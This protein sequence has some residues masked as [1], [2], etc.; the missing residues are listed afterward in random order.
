VGGA[1]VIALQAKVID[2]LSD[3]PLT[4]DQLAADVG[5]PDTAE[6]IFLLLEH[7]VAKGRAELANAVSGS[8]RRV[9]KDGKR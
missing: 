1:S 7:L 9:A 8:F 6:T 2:A 5:A 3:K 4:P